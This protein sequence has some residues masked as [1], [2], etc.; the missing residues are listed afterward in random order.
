MCSSW[1]PCNNLLWSQVSWSLQYRV[2]PKNRIHPFVSN[3]DTVVIYVYYMGIDSKTAVMTVLRS[4]SP[5]RS[6]ELS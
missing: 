5:R 3:I 6:I 1:A 4:N 2:L